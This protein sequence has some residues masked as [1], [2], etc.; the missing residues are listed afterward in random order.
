M[1]VTNLHIILTLTSVSVRLLCIPICWYIFEKYF[2]L[3]YRMKN[4]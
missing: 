1:F 3:K 4:V 2:I